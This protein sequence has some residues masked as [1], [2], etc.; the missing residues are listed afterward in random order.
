M[1][2]TSARPHAL[3]W[4]FPDFFSF[5]STLYRS[6]TNL[7]CAGSTSIAQHLF[8]IYIVDINEYQNI[9]RNKKASKNNTLY[10]IV[11]EQFIGEGIRK[12]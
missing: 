9:Q 11:T 6:L 10:R 3:M 4:K 7:V 12:L 8:P 5:L 1:K 2:F